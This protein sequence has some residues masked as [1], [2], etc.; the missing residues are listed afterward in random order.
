MVTSQTQKDN[1]LMTSL[2]CRVPK[3]NKHLHSCNRKQTGCYQDLGGVGER[4]MLVKDY[5]LSVVR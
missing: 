5:T 2:V 1:Y 3:Q 4:D